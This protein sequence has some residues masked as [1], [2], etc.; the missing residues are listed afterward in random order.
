MVAGFPWWPATILGFLITGLGLSNLVPIFI[1]AAGA[2]DAESAGPGV[3]TVSTMG[4]L[5]LLAGPP[6]IG[7]LSTL[8]SL[9]V[10]FLPVILFGIVIAFA[11]VS[12]LHRSPKVR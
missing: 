3:A 1:S 10:A 2:S 9:R 8:A 6:V 11:G 4:Y 7:A 5:G 12:A